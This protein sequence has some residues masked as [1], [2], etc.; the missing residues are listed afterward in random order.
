LAKLAV[1]LTRAL[2]DRREAGAAGRLTSR[3]LAG[4]DGWSVDDVL[5]TSGPDDLTFEEVHPVVRVVIVCAGTFQYSSGRRRELM[6]PGSVLLGNPTQC[7]VCGHEHDSGDRCLSFGYHPDYFARLVAGA[8]LPTTAPQFDRLRLPPTRELADVVSAAC[9]RLV[10]E[11]AG[12]APASWEEHSVALAVRAARLSMGAA[13]SLSVPRGAESRVTRIVRAIDRDPGEAL[14]LPALAARA[15][16][17][18]F[19]FLRTFH[20]LTGVTPHQYLLRVRLRE[21]ALRLAAE[22]S[23]VLDVALECGFGDV[24]NFNRA[25][26]A[27]FGVSPRAYRARLQA[28][29]LTRDDV[30]ISIS[31]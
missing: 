18:T 14:S 1:P 7:F 8:D 22:P 29:R 28:D 16:L 10:Q 2:A 26:R 23:R 30:H 11:D 6:T 20:A 19:H 15:R 21:A 4:G 12:V 27:E 9:G 25:F 31:R 13:G 24:S 17:S 3:H 5:C